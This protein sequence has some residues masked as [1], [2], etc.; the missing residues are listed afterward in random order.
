MRI[1]DRV[2]AIA[3]VFVVDGISLIPGCSTLNPAFVVPTVRFELTRL[4][5][6]PPQDGVSANSTTSAY[7]F[8]MMNAA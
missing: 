6:P 5:P 1:E 8:G 2:G 3:I 4:A 7:E